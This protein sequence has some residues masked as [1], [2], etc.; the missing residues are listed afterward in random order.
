MDAVRGDRPDFGGFVELHRTL[1][2]RCAKPAR[3]PGRVDGGTMGID[4]RAENPGD[5]ELAPC[6]VGVDE[7]QVVFS[8]ALV[9]A[10]RPA[11]GS[12]LQDVLRTWRPPQSHPSRSGSR[13]REIPMPHPP[14]PP[15]R[16][17][18]VHRAGGGQPVLLGDSAVG[19]R[20]ERRA[21]AA[22]SARRAEPGD[23]AL[24]HDDPQARV[25]ARKV[26]GGPQPRVAGADDRH[27][28]VYIA[29]ERRAAPDTGS[30]SVSHHNE[31]RGVITSFEFRA[32]AWPLSGPL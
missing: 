22:V 32:G 12:P 20:E 27:V 7:P 6:L 1:L 28:C 10:Q 29:V 3:K 31:P 9:R 24:E 30:A 13:S 17:W 2:D 21:P 11:P 16:T 25:E 8:V 14:R 18:P 23:G 5:A 26:V 4:E 15:R 19:R